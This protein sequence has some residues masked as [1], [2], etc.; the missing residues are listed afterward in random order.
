MQV[1]LCARSWQNP[2]WA[3]ETTPFGEQ[4]NIWRRPVPAQLG[5]DG[6]VTFTDGQFLPHVD[7]IVYATGYHYV[8]PFLSK[9]IVEI[10]D[11][12]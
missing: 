10:E 3:S 2:A 4:H 1:Y 6:S 12:M 7:S 11:N 8:F 9:G 5:R